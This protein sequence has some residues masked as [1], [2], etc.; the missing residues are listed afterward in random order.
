MKVSCLGVMYRYLDFAKAFDSV[1]HQWLKSKLRTYGF[2]KEL[3]EIE[4]PFPDGRAAAGDRI[5]C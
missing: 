2:S 1:S 5:W 3:M 4:R